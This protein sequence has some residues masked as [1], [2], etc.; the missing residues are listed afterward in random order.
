MRFQLFFQNVLLIC[1]GGCEVHGS[2]SSL[3]PSGDWL[4]VEIQKDPGF[5]W[6]LVGSL[7]G[8]LWWFSEV[9]GII[10]EVVKGL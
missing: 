3:G 4:T 5:K 8:F 2:G 10:E 7:R 9:L 6:F 1:D